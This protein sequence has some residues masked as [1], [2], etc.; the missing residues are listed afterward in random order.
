[1]KILVSDSLSA[2]G[3]ELLQERVEV[4]YRPGLEPGELLRIIGDYDALIVRSGTKVTAAVIEAGRNLK[5]IGRAGAGV[6]NIDVAKA[7][8]KGI[9]VINAPEGNTVST[10]EHSI[11]MLASLARNIPA[12]NQAYK[13]GAARREKYMGV[14][15]RGKVLGIIGV[16]RIGGEVARRAGAMGMKLLAY[17]PYIAAERIKKLGAEPVDLDTIMQQ[18]DF[19]TLHLPLVASTRHII[20]QKELAAMKPGARIINCARGGL[21][22]EAALLSALKEGKVAGAALD[23]FENDDPKENEL[24]QLDNVVATPHLGAS[25]V[26]AQDNVAVLVAEQVLTALGGELVVSAVNAPGLSREVMVEVKPFLPLMHLLGSF[27][28]QVF[29]GSIDAVEIHYSGEVADKPLPSLTTFC[30]IGMLEVILGQQVNFVNAPVIVKERGI[31]VTE[32]C[33][34][35]IKNYTNHVTVTVFS[36]DQSYT[37]AGTVLNGDELHIVQI[38]GYTIDVTPS[39]YMAVTTHRDNPGVVGRVGTILGNANINIAGMQVGRQFIGGQAVMVIQVDEPIPEAVLREL[40]SLDTLAAG[41]FV[42][43]KCHAL[44]K[45]ERLHE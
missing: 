30:L 13:Q 18:A 39:R 1:M 40:C 27:L 24:F 35:S 43:L 3:R 34:S 32:T 7:T 28:V 2:K 11:A 21:V 10:A 36:G 45:P 15:L 9:F 23:V 37:V 26:E 22:D 4:D 38:G 12:A 44:I 14:E 19:I 20:G 16:G 8:E 17:D 29:S 33:T 41:H 42:E 25:T 31:K 5:A 6:D